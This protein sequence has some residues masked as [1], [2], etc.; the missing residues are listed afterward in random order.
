MSIAID[1][2]SWWQ[3]RGHRWDFLMYSYLNSLNAFDLPLNVWPPECVV[4]DTDPHQ[5]LR[6]NC[7]LPMDS[8]VGMSIGEVK[9]Y[10]WHELETLHLSVKLLSLTLSPSH[11]ITSIAHLDSNVYIS[12]LGTIWYLWIPKWYIMWS[13]EARRRRNN[14]QTR[15]DDHESDFY[16]QCL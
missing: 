13:Q 10:T 14:G 1:A 4:H 7:Y 16:I 11:N 3:M 6:S 2:V 5:L 9:I 8:L 12:T 15:N